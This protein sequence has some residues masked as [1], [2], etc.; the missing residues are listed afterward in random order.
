METDV[1]GGTFMHLFWSEG[2]SQSCYACC[3][4]SLKACAEDSAGLHGAKSIR[5]LSLLF[6]YWGGRSSQR[7]W[8]IVFRHAHI[9]DKCAWK[10]NSLFLEWNL[11]WVSLHSNHN[12]IPEF[13]GRNPALWKAHMLTASPS[14]NVWQGRW[15]S[16]R[17]QNHEV[18]AQCTKH[19]CICTHGLCHQD[20]I[21]HW[22]PNS[23][24]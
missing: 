19:R 6:L 12:T 24:K 22:K 16:W 20:I 11:A 17:G 3:A 21:E 13:R 2:S 5:H 7:L 15:R 8:L 4:I 9:P 23:I 1:S 14:F 10:N 18:N